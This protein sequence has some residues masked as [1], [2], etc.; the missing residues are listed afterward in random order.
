MSVA[1]ADMVLT[2]ARRLRD[3]LK[4]RSGATTS[5]SDDEA[6]AETVAELAAVVKDHAREVDHARQHRRDVVSHGDPYV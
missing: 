4:R 2:K 6:I 5:L 3:N 1:A